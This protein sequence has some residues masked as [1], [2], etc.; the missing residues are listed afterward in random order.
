MFENVKPEPEDIFGKTDGASVQPVV[1]NNPSLPPPIPSLV[2]QP[3]APIYH[4]AKSAPWKTILIISGGVLIIAVAAYFISR[5]LLS[6]PASETVGVPN[7]SNA[8]EENI[9]VESN[10]DK[11]SS[12]ATE[13]EV[14]TSVIEETTEAIKDSDK[15]GLDD[16]K[17]AELGTSAAKADTDADGLFD[18][19]EVEVYKTNPL[20]PD[21]DGDS[22]LD[23][24]E[25]KNGYN[26]NGAGKLLVVPG[27]K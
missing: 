25:V 23:G 7:V 20:S 15:D 5:V 22:Y 8:V 4:P 10:S 2:S 9:D 12:T 3:T 21:T 16:A 18:R 17:E 6:A 24:D 11:N 1:P 19:E 13:P 26:P 14:Q 27:N